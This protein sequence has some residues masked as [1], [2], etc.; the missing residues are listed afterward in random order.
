MLYNWAQKVPEAF[1]VCYTDCTYRLVT[2]D[3]ANGN[4]LWM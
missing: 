3:Q 1:L 2:E 4:G